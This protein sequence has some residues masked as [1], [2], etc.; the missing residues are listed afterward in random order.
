MKP[1]ILIQRLHRRLQKVTSIKQMKFR[2][3]HEILYV[4]GS[5]VHFNV[6][7]ISDSPGIPPSATAHELFKGFSYVAPTLLY[8]VNEASSTSTLISHPSEPSSLEKN[9]EERISVEFNKAIKPYTVTLQN[10]VHK[11][12][13]SAMKLIPNILICK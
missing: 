11:L 7:A 8:V 6:T 12:E 9:E 2:L 5:N 1:F 10:M 3:S 4:L 13:I